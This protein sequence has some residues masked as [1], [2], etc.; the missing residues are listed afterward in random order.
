MCGLPI[1]C[2]GLDCSMLTCCHPACPVGYTV[3][4]GAFNG[5]GEHFLSI[6]SQLYIF[7]ELTYCQPDGTCPYSSA[8]CIDT[9]CCN[10][11]S[12]PV[13][14]TTLPPP[15][16]GQDGCPPGTTIDAQMSK[17]FLTLYTLFKS[18]YFQC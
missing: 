5:T 15:R 4:S 14:T 16:P 6:S 9:I 12:K 11:N 3:A 18:L 17:L 2:P 13:V 8:K 7:L 1:R 10:D